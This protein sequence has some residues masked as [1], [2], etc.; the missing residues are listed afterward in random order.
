MHVGDGRESGV[1][2]QIGLRWRSLPEPYCT[3]QGTRY[4]A[5]SRRDDRS[6]HVGPAYR[7]EFDVNHGSDFL[8]KYRRLTI[9]APIRPSCTP[10]ERKR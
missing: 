5:A 8:A 9:D 10:V 7:S 3:A 2:E 1:S 4:S 6:R